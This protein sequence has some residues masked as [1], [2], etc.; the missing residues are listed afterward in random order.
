V[1]RE[2]L[3]TKE[4]TT[5]IDIIQEN[6]L[7]PREGVKWMNEKKMFVAGS[8]V[9]IAEHK[10]YLEL[11]NLVCYYDYPNANGSQVNYGTTDE[12]K[13]AT[14]ERAK[15]LC[16]MP[17]YAKCAT[18]RN[19]DPT[20]KGHEIS[21]GPK[22]ELKFDTIPIGTHYSVKIKKHNVVAADGTAHRLPCLFSKQRI[23]KRNKNA[24][25]AIQRLFGEGKLFN[26]YEMDV[27]QYT[28]KDGI[29]HLEDYSFLG[30][31]F[32]GYE[33]ATPA[34]GTGGGS[35][36]LSVA[37]AEDSFSDAE[38][39]I[40]EA[41]Y[42][43]N[44]ENEVTNCEVNEM[45][46]EEFEVVVEAIDEVETSE[47][48]A[49]QLAE[50][51]EEVV[52]SEEQLPETEV[53]TEEIQNESEIAQEEAEVSEE[54]EQTPTQEPEVS[55]LTDYDIRRKL[56]EAL[57]A[58]T[59]EYVYC[60]HLFPADNCAWVKLDSD[61]AAGELS[62]TEVVYE[63]VEDVVTILSMTPISLTAS[64]RELAT[65]LSERE[66]ELSEIKDELSELKQIKESYDKI[67]MEQ[68][69]AKRKQDIA[70]L[71]KYVQNAG[72]FTEEELAE[73]N[74][75]K[76]IED[77]QIAEVKA[78]IADKL[79]AAKLEKAPVVE[80]AS[81]TMPKVD[82]GFEAENVKKSRSRQWADFISK[83]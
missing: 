22:G 57:Y 21:R 47:E 34:Y 11:E 69:E 17:V 1:D 23:W 35:Q 60:R 5:F 54:E 38:L 48:V 71:Q 83:K 53:E 25:A 3:L 41:L 70:E 32:L 73:E 39:M 65:V 79:I 14:L 74:L 29:K 52:V 19:G 56:E 49:E 64:P 6:N 24:V 46:N 55:A 31:A 81:M 7:L 26:S 40:A 42:Q 68:A 61:R 51:V 13:A 66:R 82:L 15:T 62:M 28:F 77:L 4:L 12:E 67:V 30:N 75:V 18:N 63:V 20:F 8:Y 43:D 2:P 9:E 72:C 36:V 44:L 37:T 50:E 58:S 45:P 33:Y 80:Q 59:K 16:L 27:S 76:L 10:N 78:L